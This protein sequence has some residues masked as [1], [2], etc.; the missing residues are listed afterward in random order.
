VI[1]DR[2]MHILPP[3]AG[4]AAAAAIAVNPMPDPVNAAQWLDIQMQ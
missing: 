3:N 4:G 2:H 1:I